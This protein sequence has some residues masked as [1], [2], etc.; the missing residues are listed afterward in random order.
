MIYID[1]AKTDYGRQVMKKLLENLNTHKRVMGS[2]S[3]EANRHFYE[4]C[5]D[6]EQV[7]KLY[8]RSHLRFPKW[9]DTINEPNGRKI[10][11]GKNLN[12]SYANV[13]LRWTD[14]E[15]HAL[16]GKT[17]RLKEKN[18]IRPQIAVT[19][20]PYNLYIQIQKLCNKP[21]GKN[22]VAMDP[23]RFQSEEL[24]K[25]RDRIEIIPL[26]LYLRSGEYTTGRD[27]ETIIY[28]PRRTSN[29]S[30]FAI[31]IPQDEELAEI[32]EDH[33]QFDAECVAAG[34]RTIQR[35]LGKGALR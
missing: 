33:E 34:R 24:R 7:E 13:G 12:G 19:M 25:L 26:F 31:P 18:V 32:R 28:R 9:G 23:A 4:E 2:E 21:F 17:F 27:I 14:G 3:P 30:R 20:R 35:I 16:L 11:Y 1:L 6:P 10:L 22:R 5:V 15:Q 8:Q 29:I